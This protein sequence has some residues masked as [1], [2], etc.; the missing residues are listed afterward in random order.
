MKFFHSSSRTIT[1]AAFLLATAALASRVLGLARD[2]I[3][4]EKFGAGDEL[5]IYF[6]AFRVP[7]LVYNIVIAG[8]ISSAFIPVFIS[9][10]TRNKEEAWRVANNF[11]NIALLGLLVFSVLFVF[12]APFFVSIIAPGFDEEKTARTVLATRIMFLSPLFLGA[13]AILGGILHSFKRFFTYAAAPIFYNLGI[14]LGAIFL[15]DSL[16]VYGLAIGVALGSFLHFII[17]VPSVMFC[18]FAWRA[19]ADFHD[20]SLRKI[21]FLVIPRALGFAIFQL[22]L[23][24]ITAIASLLPVGSVAIFNFANH[25]QFLPIGIIGYSFAT[26]AMPSFAKSAARAKREKLA[27]Q[28]QKTTRMILFFV[29]PLSIVIFVLRAHI[30]RVVFGAGAFSW[31]DTRLTAAA[32]GI[33]CLGIWAHSLIPVLS[34]IFYAFQNTKTPVIIN[35]ISFGMNIVLSLVF[36]FVALKNQLIVQSVSDF[37]DL[38]GIDDISILGL[39][40]AFAISGIINLKILL[41]Y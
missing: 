7:D 10:Y 40:L 21:F 36:V 20:R 19:I 35:S 13:S 14:I 2:R 22:N 25:L 11:L 4:A 34:K 27:L 12:L 38:N 24:V 29:L 41:K 1:S 17:Q 3:F 30:V 31:T 9:V 23:W 26:A 18:G 28:F 33:F 6:A 8:A 5:D 32:L 39:P 37:L 16:G 15:G